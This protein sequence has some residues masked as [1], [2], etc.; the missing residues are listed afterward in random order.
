MTSAPQSGGTNSY[1]IE[2]KEF[3]APTLLPGLYITATPIGNLA[4]ITI[5][6]LGTLAGADIVLCEDTRHTR[7]L[8]DRYG[9]TASLHAYHDHNGARMRPRIQGWIG[10]GKSV[11]LVSDAG[12][13]LVSDPGYKLASLMRE[14]GHDVHV[15]PGASAPIAALAVSGVPS[16][17]FLF[18]GFL[19]PK[20]QARRNLLA[21]LGKVRATL[22]FFETA[23]RLRASLADIGAVLGA[24]Q[25]AVAREL[26]KIHE[27][28]LAGSADEVA[29]KFTVEKGEI[30]LLIAPGD[31]EASGVDD[32][33]ID[34]QLRDALATMPAGK[35]AS[36]VAKSLGIKRNQLYQRA[37]E[38]K[39][40][41][42]ANE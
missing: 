32:S 6:A 1:T 37:L 34:A 7:R 14:N 4:D 5:R 25:V 38:L 30:T 12:M 28:V 39:E 21:E 26:T 23:K 31:E 15:V 22:I 27:E 16:D 8:L 40:D 3:S 35:A 17:R 11:V 10:E 42:A 13:P 9:I 24:R 36:A 33:E 20:S 41:L 29:E 19:P 18:A 2:E